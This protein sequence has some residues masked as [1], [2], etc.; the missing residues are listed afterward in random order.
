MARVLVKPKEWKVDCNDCG[1]TIAFTQQDVRE[2]EGPRGT[3]TKRIACPNC[4][5]SIDVGTEDRIIC[6][7]VKE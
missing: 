2:D 3:W 1:S 5:N 4:D 7:E 6:E